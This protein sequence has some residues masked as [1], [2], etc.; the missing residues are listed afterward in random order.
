MSEFFTC[1]HASSPNW[2][3]AAAQCLQQAGKGP[4]GA[5]LGFLYVADN[6]AGEVANILA[7]FRTNT[8]ILHWT[9]TVAWRGRHRARILRRAGTGDHAVRL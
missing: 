5:N 6:F 3:D 8:G 1:G 2:R 7:Y 9:G 4:A